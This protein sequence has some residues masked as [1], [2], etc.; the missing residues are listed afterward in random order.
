MFCENSGIFTLI[1]VFISVIVYHVLTQ[2]TILFFKLVQEIVGKVLEKS[3]FTGKTDNCT[4]LDIFMV[5]F[6]VKVIT[7][8]RL[9]GATCVMLMFF[10][11]QICGQ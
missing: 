5:R 10:C 7:A 9:T 1:T 4:S 11:G 2:M 6:V 8:K 3:Y